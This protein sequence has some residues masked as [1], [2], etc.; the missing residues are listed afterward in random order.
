MIYKA[1]FEVIYDASTNSYAVL[2]FELEGATSGET[3]EN[4]IE[5]AVDWLQGEV[6]ISLI[7]DLELPETSLNHKPQ[8]G[9]EVITVGV[10]ATLDSIP[11]MSATDAAKK[12]GVSR[13]RV[14]QLCKD[15]L[16]ENWKV[17][18]QRRIAV[19]SVEARLKED[20]QPGRPVEK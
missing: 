17:G 18:S 15:K 4:A 20:P 14:A 11:S 6:E 3:F 9:G 1:Q 10:S 5:M 12:L 16:L 8:D 7:N 2:P 13:A 19:A